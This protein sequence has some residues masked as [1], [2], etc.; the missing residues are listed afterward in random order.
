MGKYLLTVK[1]VKAILHT[2][3]LHQKAIGDNEDNDS[4]LFVKFGKSSKKKGCI[5][6]TVLGSVPVTT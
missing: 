4:G 5:S 3:E 2:R 6:V 1:V